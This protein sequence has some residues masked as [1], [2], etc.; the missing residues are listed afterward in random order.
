MAKEIIDIEALLHRAYAQYRVE[1]VGGSAAGRMIGR[2]RPIGFATPS[3]AERVDTSAPGSRLA[4]MAKAASSVPDDILALHDH[5]LALGEMWLAW[6]GDEVG[7]WD[8]QSAA[9]AGY[10][11][12]QAAGRWWLEPISGEALPSEIEQVGVMALVVQH[13]REGTRPDWHPGWAP[14]KGRPA[15]DGAERDAR[16]R[17]RKGEAVPL[18]D[19]QA[20]RAAYHA[21][22]CALVLLQAQ[23]EGQ[24]RL[25]DVT[26]PAAPAAPWLEASD[27]AA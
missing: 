20:D 7:I 4:A 24:S 15:R 17:R 6:Y 22:R 21:W 5:V 10:I 14:K 26:G 18:R 3:Y 12:A 23:M 27:A 8:R 19:M 1:K 9:Q 25:V 2:P 16:G 11:V 13:A